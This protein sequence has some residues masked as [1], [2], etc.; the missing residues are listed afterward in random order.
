MN[1]IIKAKNL[2]K[3]YQ[4]PIKDKKKGFFQGLKNIFSKEY[5]NKI[6]LKDVSFEI[7]KGEI[8]GYIGPN[9]AG[10]STTIKILTGIITPS[11]G[12]CKVLG[13]NPHEDRYNY[14]KNIGVVFGQRR[15]LQYDVAVIESFKL[16]KEIYEMSQKDFEE[17]LQYFN[18]ILNLDKYLHIPVRKLSLGER[19]RC[20]IAASLLH[21]PKIVFLDEPTIGLDA[22]AKEEIREFLKEINKK[23]NTT[24][25][26]TTH[27]MDDIEELCD[28]VIVIDEGT[29]IYDGSLSEL[30]KKSIIH[31]TIEVQFKKI[32]SQ[33]DYEYLKNHKGIEIIDEKTNFLKIKVEFKDYKITNVVRDLLEILDVI[34]ISVHE[35]RLEYII[36]E[37]YNNGINN[38]K[39]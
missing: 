15:L 32:N 14:T 34:D 39:N 2:E 18:K 31:K 7:E 22:V 24:I 4:V 17:R 6:A 19:M 30:Q 10:K 1:T 8:I 16:Y 20:E 11:K 37:I 33:K 28:R 36:K 12:T 21:K 5:T 3:I 29:L 27:D 13:F 23:D 9:G 26:L 38:S 35:P 25:I